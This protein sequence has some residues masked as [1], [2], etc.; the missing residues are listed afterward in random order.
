MDVKDSV[1][2]DKELEIALSRARR[3][4]RVATWVFSKSSAGASFGFATWALAKG[5]HT[6]AGLVLCCAVCVSAFLVLG[7]L[8]KKLSDLIDAPR[9]RYYTQEAGEDGA[10]RSAE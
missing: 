8:F 5:P 4:D 1:R 3:H 10:R 6:A 2:D 7:F 9:R